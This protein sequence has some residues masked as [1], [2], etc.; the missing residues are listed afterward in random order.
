MLIALLAACAGKKSD[1]DE[2]PGIQPPPAPASVESQLF[3][4]SGEALL[5]A[6]A[7]DLLPP[8]TAA[9]LVASNLRELHAHLGLGALEGEAAAAFRSVARSAI[10]RDVL[11][12]DALEAAGLDLHRPGAVALVAGAVVIVWPLADDRAF[13]GAWG[14]GVGVLVRDGH[15]LL[16]APLDGG[17]PEARVDRLR[18]L[19]GD[20]SLA[21]TARYREAA[22]ALNYGPDAAVFVNVG[23][24]TAPVRTHLEARAVELAQAAGAARTEAAAARPADR[25][26]LDRAAEAAESLRAE[27]AVELS[28]YDQ[29]VTPMVGAAAGVG[30]AD[31]GALKLQ[32][33]VSLAADR[34]G[35]SGMHAGADTAAPGARGDR[36]GSLAVSLT[37]AASLDLLGW[38]I[39]PIPVIHT[40]DGGPDSFQLDSLAGLLAG[41]VA[42]SVWPEPPRWG[43]ALSL[44]LRD[45][46]AT[47]SMLRAWAAAARATGLPV[48][49]TGDRVQI[50][51][52]GVPWHVAVTDD[53][54]VAA[55]DERALVHTDLRSLARVE[56]ELA[57]RLHGVEAAAG[58]LCIEAGVLA[59]LVERVVARRV[60]RPPHGIA[61]LGA[62]TEAAAGDQRRY[63]ELARERGQ[64]AEAISSRRHDR[65]AALGRALGTSVAFA[66]A[67]GDTITLYGAQ[68]LG[69]DDTGALTRR[70][71]DLWYEHSVAHPAVRELAGLDR[72]LRR[73]YRALQ[74]VSS[75]AG[76]AG[77]GPASDARAP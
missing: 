29:L 17:A 75:A 39:G 52:G 58:G 5:G 34:G 27:A 30:F 53:H 71:V 72:E 55:T 14:G 36:V 3:P 2:R 35:W 11:D 76:G 31:D 19:A 7:I 56:H 42:V 28:L 20:A 50:S 48:E 1:G 41:D 43:V 18:A 12:P 37:P 44:R 6:P 73:Q 13:E 26:R 9:V 32:I 61:G 67:D 47:A 60:A 46:G 66:R 51:V 40:S 15:G 23:A 10:G 33:S 21:H 59:Y 38:L 62:T 4:P 49:A 24:L 25:E 74:S 64:V 57:E 22:R 8:E 54:L 77:P 70:L 16:I 68:F 45:A 69:V 65:R 63:L